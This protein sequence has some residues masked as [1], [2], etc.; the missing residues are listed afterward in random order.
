MPLKC[1]DCRFNARRF[2][3]C[4]R[5]YLFH[6]TD[7]ANSEMF[8]YDIFPKFGQTRLLNSIHARKHGSFLGQLLQAVQF[9]FR[10][11][12]KRF[13]SPVPA[14]DHCRQYAAADESGRTR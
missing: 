1:E 4:G 9:L 12:L 13:H 8:Q 7:A 11:G 14:H 5:S 2:E 6:G 3:K 10:Q